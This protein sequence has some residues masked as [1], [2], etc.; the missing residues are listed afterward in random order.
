MA[1]RLTKLPTVKSKL[2]MHMFTEQIV[3]NVLILRLLLRSTCDSKISSRSDFGSIG[4]MK[5]NSVAASLC[6]NKSY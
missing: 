6:K 5:T 4:D 2:L 3:N 1:G